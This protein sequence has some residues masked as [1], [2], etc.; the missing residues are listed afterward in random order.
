MAAEEAARKTSIK[1]LFP[2]VFF[3]LPAMLLVILGPA[4]IQIME[5]FRN[6]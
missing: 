6:Q 2:L 1:M 5:V 3:I 4:V